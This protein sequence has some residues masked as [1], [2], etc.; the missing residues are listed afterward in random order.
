MPAIRDLVERLPPVPSN[1]RPWTGRVA[2]AAHR[3]YER[4]SQKAWFRKLVVGVFLAYAALILGLLLLVVLALIAAAS[5]GVRIRLSLSV[6]ELGGA[7][8]D[9]VATGLIVMGALRLRA[10]RTIDGYRLFY[11]ALL[12]QI[13]IGQVFAFIDG[14][15]VAVW[16]FLVAPDVQ[17]LT[18]AFA[19]NR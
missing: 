12:V 13:F 10:H 8:S 14:S 17:R 7:I 4:I 19:P 15:F 9:F 3:R 18:L 1:Q 16:G 6:T 11:R 5:A 2:H